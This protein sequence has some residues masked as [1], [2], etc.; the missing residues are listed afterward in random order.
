MLV[1]K[2]VV[3]KDWGNKEVVWTLTSHGRT[4]ESYGSLAPEEELDAGVI[5]QNR[6]GGDVIMGVPNEPPSVKAGPAQTITLPSAAT[7][8]AS[9]NAKACAVVGRRAHCS[10]VSRSSV[11]NTIGVTGRPSW[12][13]DARLETRR[14]P[15]PVTCP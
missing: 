3:P 11:V 7:L 1:F 2:V 13:C 10:I 5:A 8:T 12:C 6:F 14:P 15:S 9:R 4:E